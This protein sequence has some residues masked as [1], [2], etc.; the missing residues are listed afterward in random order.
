MND[1]QVLNSVE[2]TSEVETPSSNQSQSTANS[3]AVNYRENDD[4]SLV[5][6]AVA[7]LKP[8]TTP[9]GKL[10]LQ[11][12]IGLAA[13][14]R[15]KA[16][17]ANCIPLVMDIMRTIGE[18]NRQDRDT[19]V[20]RVDGERIDIDKYRAWEPFANLVVAGAFTISGSDSAIDFKKAEDYSMVNGSVLNEGDFAKRFKTLNDNLR[21]KWTLVGI[22][23][24]EWAKIEATDQCT[25]CSGCVESVDIKQIAYQTKSF[26]PK[27]KTV[28]LTR[29][30]SKWTES[31][32]EMTYAPKA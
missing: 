6:K 5:D 28:A 19:N 13:G 2:K 20:I 8:E 15:N 10:A 22:T 4:R 3:G 32:C 7:K 1:N 18:M 9:W 31:I 11:I 24:P 25:V 21:T 23:R 16:E 14:A 27:A 29:W 30:V 26:D 12:A 17:G